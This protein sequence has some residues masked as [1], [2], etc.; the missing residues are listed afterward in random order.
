VGIWLVVWLDVGAL[1]GTGTTERCLRLKRTL[2][3]RCSREQLI[4]G[5]LAIRKLRTAA[6]SAGYGEASIKRGGD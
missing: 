4:G 1:Y 2:H 3:G 5:A 6:Y